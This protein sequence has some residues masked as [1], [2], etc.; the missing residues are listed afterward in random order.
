[1]KG[2][3]NQVAEN[4]EKSVSEILS[5]KS[6]H[7]R[8]RARKH[9]RLGERERYSEIE[10]EREREERKDEEREERILSVTYLQKS[11]SK[12]FW[13]PEKGVHESLAR[14]CLAL[15]FQCFE[16]DHYFDSHFQWIH[17][18]DGSWTRHFLLPVEKEA[19]IEGM[20]LL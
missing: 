2:S 12:G 3:V 9:L 15:G 17:S 5:E 20:L 6:S 13:E 4:W 10:D 8:V 14:K 18:I 16:P 19:V 11:P 1:M 7:W